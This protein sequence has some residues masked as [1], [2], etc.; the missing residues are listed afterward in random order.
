MIDGKTSLI[1]LL[2][3]PVRHSLSPLIHNAALKEMGINWTYLAF[4]CRSESLNIVLKA[5]Q[6]LDFKGLNITIPHKRTITKLCSDLTETS[7]KVQA[8]NTLIPTEDGW[9]GDNTD[10]YGFIA[11][12]LGNQLDNKNA[13]IIG[14]GGSARAAIAGLQKLH[15][16]SITIAGRNQESLD[17]YITEIH[18]NYLELKEE[19]IQIK[20]IIQ[21]DER[22]SQIIRNSDIIINTTPVGMLSFDKTNELST[23]V[24]L[25]IE[26][27]KN[28]NKNTIL[29][30]LIYTP[31]PTEW[32]KIG[33]QHGCHTIDGLEMLIQQGAA[34]LRTWT[35]YQQIP[36]NLMRKTAQN[37]L[38]G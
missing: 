5:L 23:H 2:G 7:K 26:I 14:S 20:G 10:V 1:G 9:I 27:W 11:P 30:D 12:L 36:I 32:L 24:P 3:N 15:I 38:K 29:Y 13:L 17:K 31:R 22:L 8:V 21:T 35:N 18:T 34:S 37:H 16:D 6:S 28:L 19:A 33:Q 4:P 25:G